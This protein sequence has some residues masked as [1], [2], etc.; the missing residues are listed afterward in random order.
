M[1]TDN[2]KNVVLA[3]PSFRRMI[4]C[5]GN[6]IMG[7]C[8]SEFISNKTLLKLIDQ[9]LAVP[10]GKAV[11]STDEIYENEMVLKVRCAP[12]KDRTGLNL[13]TITV[14][15][16]IT[17]LKQMDQMKSDFV[18]LVSHEIRS[19]L[20]SLLMQ[21]KVIMDGLAGEISDKQEEILGRASK[22]VSNL[23]EMASDLLDLAK[24]ESGLISIEKEPIQINTLLKEQIS[25]FMETFLAKQISIHMNLDRGL[26][27]I[28]GNY[29]NLE[30]VVSNLLTNAAK[31]T[32]N[33]GDIFV[34]TSTKDHYICIGIKDTGFGI[35]SE[36]I[37]KIFDKF[38]RI[39]N[40]QT[41]YITGTG[42]GLAIVKSILEAHSGSIEVES[43]PGSG[44]EF[45]IQLPYN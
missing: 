25:F 8:V 31:Y 27:D 13:G 36:E 26:P 37:D 11:E 9:A 12:F 35:S 16:D 17:T 34:T 19:P 18:S 32:P 41:R 33:G 29:Q 20:N 15:N 45:M 21:I 24:I 44:S 6:D 39:K 40:D 43:A 10:I 38:Y 23:I 42:L 3:N 22:K 14:L 1:A 7:Q 2:Q 4:D 30:E 5:Q 28:M